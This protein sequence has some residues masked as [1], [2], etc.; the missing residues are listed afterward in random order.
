V[1]FEKAGSRCN[2]KYLDKALPHTAPVSSFHHLR[3]SLFL[4]MVGSTA[5]MG[6]YALLASSESTGR[7][8]QKRDCSIN[9]PAYE[10]DTCASM[11]D[12]W[13]ISEAQFLSYNP[14]AVCSALE[15]GKEYCVEWSGTLPALPEPPKTSSTPTPTPI[16]TPTTLSTVSSIKTISNAPVATCASS[17][18]GVVT[19]SPIQVCTEYIAN[20]LPH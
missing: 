12:S 1:K 9:F 13:S 8:L 19:P 3:W 17:P 2:H 6:I 7:N 11:A 14:G 16:P 15:I 20:L 5:L 10:D 4:T 18:A